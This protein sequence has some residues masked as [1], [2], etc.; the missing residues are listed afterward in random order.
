MGPSPEDLKRTM[1]SK[2]DEELYLLLRLH[3]HDYSPEAV[4]AATEEFDCRKLDEATMSRIIAAAERELEEETGS[5]KASQ[6]P[7]SDAKETAAGWGCLIL[8]CFAGY[9]IYGGYEWLDTMGWISHREDSVITA[10]SG[11]LVGESKECWSAP[12]NAEGAAQ[13]GK[14]IGDESTYSPLHALA[15]GQPC[16]HQ[17][18]VGLIYLGPNREW[19]T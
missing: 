10:G 13:S 9:A 16:D 1:Q 4:K 3:S 11:W 8:L 5:T 6:R 17:R 14:P 15:P 7:T 18:P 2:T 19:S 12:L